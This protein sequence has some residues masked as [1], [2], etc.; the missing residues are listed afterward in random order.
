M[1]K[2]ANKDKIAN[3]KLYETMIKTERAGLEAQDALLTGVNK[4]LSKYIKE[5]VQEYSKIVLVAGGYVEV[6]TIE[7]IP[8]EGI[9]NFLEEFNFK[10]M[11]FKK[12]VIEDHSNVEV[13]TVEVITYSFLPRDIDKILGDNGVKQDREEF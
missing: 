5:D 10:M 2:D 1:A 8:Q 6:R 7:E 11:S 3:N 13:V 9:D 4:Y 12:E